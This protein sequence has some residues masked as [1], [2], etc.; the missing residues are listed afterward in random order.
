MDLSFVV[1]PKK[2]PEDKNT[3]K[4]LNET[5]ASFRADFDKSINKSLGWMDQSTVFID[6]V[7]ESQLEQSLNQFEVTQIPNSLDKTW[8][9]N[10][11]GQKTYGGF[12]DW[13]K[14]EKSG[15]INFFL[16]KREE[17]TENQ[18][19]SRENKL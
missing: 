12:E 11:K 5:W 8:L 19:A 16:E 6:K 18:S 15:V 1:N 14:D 3:P 13:V 9:Y 4:T 10:E 2:N 17:A 7:L